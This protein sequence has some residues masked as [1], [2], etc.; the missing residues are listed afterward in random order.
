MEDDLQKYNA[1]KNDNKLKQW[2]LHET[3]NYHQ[4][5][6]TA[7]AFHHELDKSIT[8]LKINNLQPESRR[9]PYSTLLLSA[10]NSLHVDIQWFSLF[11]STLLCQCVALYSILSCYKCVEC[12]GSAMWW[13]S[14]KHIILVYL[15]Y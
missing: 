2:F 5:E 9:L 12:E 4:D 7:R 14:V 8:K 13:E 6:Q 1:A 3:I 10:T 11:Y 15:Y